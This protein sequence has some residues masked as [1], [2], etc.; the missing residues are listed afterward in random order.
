MRHGKSK[1]KA[2]GDANLMAL[3]EWLCA[4]AQQAEEQTFNQQNAN[5]GG[6][7]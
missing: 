5:K 6:S 7:N 2:N 3:I 4:E 1:G